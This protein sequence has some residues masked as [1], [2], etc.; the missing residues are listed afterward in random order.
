[1]MAAIVYGLCAATAGLCAWL[2]FQAHGRTRYRLLFW[3]GLFFVIS[4]FGNVLLMV[5]KLILPLVDLSVL[6]YVVSLA[7]LW[8]LLWGLIFEVE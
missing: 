1:M 8:T 5:D 3:S 6:R 4:T 7:A 2:L